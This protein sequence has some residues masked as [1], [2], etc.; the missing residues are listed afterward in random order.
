MACIHVCPPKL[1]PFTIRLK[2][3][4]QIIKHFI[5]D[6]SDAA[7][8]NSQPNT[9]TWNYPQYTGQVPIVRSQG[10]PEDRWEPLKNQLYGTSGIEE[11]KNYAGHSILTE[12]LEQ[13]PDKK[14]W[15]C[16]VPLDGP[17]GPT[18]GA[19]FSR[20]DRAIVHIRGKHLDMRPYL[21]GNGG[22]CQMPNWLVSFSPVSFSWNKHPV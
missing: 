11:G 4:Y 6:P 16:K 10:A 5:T 22:N 15:T 2:P 7:A 20:V 19:G 17:G 8:S 21:C 14:S 12:W 18:C 13:M 3:L 1:I 9:S